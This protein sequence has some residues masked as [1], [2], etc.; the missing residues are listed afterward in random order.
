AAEEEGMLRLEQLT[1]KP[2]AF[3]SLTGLNPAAFEALY[4]D[5]GPAYQRYR[6]ATDTTRRE[7][8]PRRRAPGGGAP[9]A[10]DLRHRLL[11]ALV[12][13]RVAPAWGG[14]GFCSGR[15]RGNARRNLL[16]VLEAL[17]LLEDFPFDR[18]PPDRPA[19]PRSLAAVMEAFPAVRLVIDSQE[20]RIHR[21]G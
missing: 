12:W 11:L 3:V 20:Q 9:H 10:L 8:R 21:P 13:L 5:F 7:R 4:A 15:D 18:D 19:R 16:D 1:A 14:P 17:E 2:H 6:A